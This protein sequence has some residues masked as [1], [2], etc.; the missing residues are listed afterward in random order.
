MEEAKRKKE[1]NTT[2]EENGPD[3]LRGTS[4]YV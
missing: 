4:Q 2:N 1:E 3:I